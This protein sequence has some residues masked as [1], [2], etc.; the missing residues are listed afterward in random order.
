MSVVIP[1]LVAQTALGTTFGTSLAIPQG[2]A[3]VQVSVCTTSAFGIALFK[4]VNGQV[5]TIRNDGASP[6]SIFPQTLASIDSLAASAAYVLQSGATVNFISKDGWAWSSVSVSAPT[7]GAT[8]FASPAILTLPVVGA[9]TTLTSASPQ[10]I[11]VPTITTNNAAIALPAPAAGLQ[12]D[13]YFSSA[14]TKVVTVTATAA[15]IQGS[16]LQG[17]GTSA[18]NVGVPI[19]AKTNIIYTA[20]GAGDSINLFCDGT[21]WYAKCVSSIVTISVS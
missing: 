4:P 12:Y 3:F 1:T 15:I 8:G 9:T 14:E 5:I 13:I 11:I 17:T 21:N 20:A 7:N 2:I 16:A 18:N 6:L 19:S 10:K